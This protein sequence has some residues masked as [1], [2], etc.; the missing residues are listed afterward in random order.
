MI[1]INDAGEYVI[2][3]NQ[4]KI[5]RED[6]SYDIN[7]IREGIIGAEFKVGSINYETPASKFIKNNLNR[8]MSSYIWHKEINLQTRK[9]KLTIFILKD[10]IAITDRLESENYEKLNTQVCRSSILNI[11]DSYFLKIE[12]T[13]VNILDNTY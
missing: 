7:K 6:H 8:D 12:Y 13:S 10:L 5:Y 1:K 2:S 9:E 4:E 3:N 11:K